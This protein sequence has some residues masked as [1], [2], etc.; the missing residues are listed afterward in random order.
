MAVDPQRGL[1]TA[2]GEMAR[3][4]PGGARGIMDRP[5]EQRRDPLWADL[6]G[7]AGHVAVVGAPQSGKSTLL[8]TLISSLAL[9]HTPREA[10][11]YCSTSAAGRW[12]G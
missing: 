1:A 9:L 7:A 3:P 4:L 5:F 2:D 6:S 12:P 8:R 11:F 10:Q